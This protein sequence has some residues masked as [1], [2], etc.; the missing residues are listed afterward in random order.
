MTLLCGGNFAYMTVVTKVYRFVKT[1]WHWR[2]SYFFLNDAGFWLEDG[3][4]TVDVE[5]TNPTLLVV[6]VTGTWTVGTQSGGLIIRTE[7]YNPG[8]TPPLPQV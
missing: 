2:R 4:L 7:I 1:N 3:V 5:D 8:A 6:T